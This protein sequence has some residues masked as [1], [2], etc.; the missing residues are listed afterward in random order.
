M[1]SIDNLR[2]V[3]D[4]TSAPYEENETPFVQTELDNEFEQMIINK[5]HLT[6]KEME[7]QLTQW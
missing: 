3:M 5:Y 2:F 7:S 6:T 4:E 1:Y